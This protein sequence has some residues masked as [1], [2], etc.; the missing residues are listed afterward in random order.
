MPSPWRSL[1][2]RRYCCVIPFLI[3]T[4]L[5]AGLSL[6][7]GDVAPAFRSAY[8]DFSGSVAPERL[9]ATVD[10]LA[11]FGSRVAGYPGDL[12][13]ADYVQQQFVSLGLDKVKAD[14]FPVTVPYDLGVDDPA[15][16]AYVDLGVPAPAAAIDP[17]AA[18]PTAARAA[19]TPAGSPAARS[20]GER[21]HLPIY[22]LW[23]NL[24]RTSTLP[25]NG[26]TA[27]V[28]YVR[29]GRLRNFN[30][31]DV[32]GSIVMVD[33][34]CSAQWLNAPRLGARA[35]IFVA[36]DTTMRGEAEAK[37]ISIPIS[38]PRFYMKQ[39]DAAPLIALC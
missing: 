2:A 29:D 15:K 17:P 3:A 6:S 32:E 31:K 10:T 12:K 24:V 38:I 19:L 21:T 22:P 13:A 18:S 26:L 30:G 35:V 7:A 37:F 33:F 20:R 36:P 1:S 9:R 27:P 39:A 4:L 5:V 34:N 25:V 11:G 16:G 8:L 28:I 23:P 14:E